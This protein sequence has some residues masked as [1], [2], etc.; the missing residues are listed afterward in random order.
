MSPKMQDGYSSHEAIELFGDQ[1][2]EFEKME[3]GMYERIY[4]IGKVRRQ[5][6]YTIADKEGFYMVKQGEQ[7]AWRYEVLQVIDAGAFG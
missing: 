3:M 2:T 1:L 5:N 4:T 7:L 6:Q